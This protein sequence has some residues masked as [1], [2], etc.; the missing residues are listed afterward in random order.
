MD[1]RKEFFNYKDLIGLNY[2]TGI[3]LKEPIIKELYTPST[4]YYVFPKKTLLLDL[5][6]SGLKAMYFD[7]RLK[8]DISKHYVNI[9]TFDNIDTLFE[10]LKAKIE[11]NRFKHI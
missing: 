1:L 11:K 3:T 8:K 7:F 4:K 9:G 5:G 2:N 6:G 10:D